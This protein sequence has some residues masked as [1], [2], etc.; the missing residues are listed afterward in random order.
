MALNF[1]PP[2]QTSVNGIVV[3][4]NQRNLTMCPQSRGKV[5]TRQPKVF[6]TGPLGLR[7]HEDAVLRRKS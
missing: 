3:S 7:E 6:G 1:L 5:H 4:C 2:Y